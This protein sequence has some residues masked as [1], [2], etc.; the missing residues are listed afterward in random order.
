[1]HYRNVYFALIAILMMALSSCSSHDDRLSPYRWKRLGEPFDSL[2]LELDRKYTFFVPVDSIA[3]DVRRL[4]ELAD[5]DTA[6]HAKMARA[7]FWNGRLMSR[8][9]KVEG[10]FEQFNRALA[11]TDSSKYPYDWRRITAGL[12]RWNPRPGFAYYNM[13]A[14]DIDF[15]ESVGD[16]GMLGLR[17]MD[18][19]GFLNDL[20]SPERGLEMLQRA[21]SCFAKV[22][23]KR[24]ISDNRINRAISYFEMHRDKEGET[25]LREMLADPA[26]VNGDWRIVM[27]LYSNLYEHTGDRHDIKAAYDIVKDKPLQDGFKCKYESILAENFLKTGELDSAKYYSDRAVGRLTAVYPPAVRLVAYQSRASVMDAVGNTDSAYYYLSRGAALNDSI[28]EYQKDADVLNSETLKQILEQEHRAA[29]EQRKHTTVFIC[30]IFGVLVIAGIAAAVVY[31]R[32]QRQKLARMQ[33]KLQLEQ[34]QRQ[35]LAMRLAM[36]EKDTL[37]NELSRDLNDLAEE[38][39]ISHKASM[40][41]ENSIKTHLGLEAERKGFVQTFTEVSPAFS[42]RLKERYPALSDADVRLAS[43]IAVGLDNKHIARILS[44]R[45]DSVKQARWRLRTKLNLAGDESLDD[46][47][48]GFMDDGQ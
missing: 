30:V 18:M 46:T 43:F 31:R 2:T 15:F 35:V 16:N 21:D 38:G 19:G 33:T 37:F 4:R 28:E 32:M 29:I 20:G 22:G 13:V 7:L 12:E 5:V 8:Q 47:I 24:M 44:I 26:V 42:R 45:P 14:G 9:G 3:E 17:Y 41:L 40:K 25:L 36:E 11:M 27:I 10:A 1:M 39:D 6:N 23:W 34:S 48:A